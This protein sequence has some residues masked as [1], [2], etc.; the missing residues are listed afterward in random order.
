MDPASVFLIAIVLALLNGVVLGLAHRDMPPELRGA[1]AS[2][3][4]GTVLIAAG[5]LLLVVQGSRQIPLISI[6]FNLAICLGLTAYWRSMRLFYGIRDHWPSLLLPASLLVPGLLLYTLVWP[7]VRARVLFASL[8][9]AWPIVGALVVTLRGHP[10]D[11]ALSRR[12]LAVLFA[13][14]ALFLI[15]RGLGVWLLLP[16]FDSVFSA[17]RWINVATPLLASTLPVV[18]TTAFLQLCSERLRRQLEHAAST[19]ALTGLWNRRTLVTAGKTSLG[20]PEGRDWAVLLID[21]DHFKQV[22]DRHGHEV[23]DRALVAVSRLLAASCRDGELASR[24]GGEEFAL[25]WRVDPGLVQRAEALRERIAE[26][27]IPVRG[28]ELRL[29]ASIGLARSVGQPDSLDELLRHADAALYR[30]KREGRNQVQV[31]EGE[32]SD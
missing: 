19:D 15:V 8:L 14:V 21:I 24:H 6:S 1:T 27:R 2:W 11:R 18:G 23:G 7:D 26:A 32:G 3:G 5:C 9:D 13:F 31:F 10:G 28:G 12:V 22:N 16:D 20:G 29:T 25:L 30:A 17:G 4:L